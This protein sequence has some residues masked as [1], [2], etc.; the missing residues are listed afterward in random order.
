MR[1][2]PVGDRALLVEVSTARR[3]R[4]C[5]PSCCAAA[6]TGAALRARDRP[7]RPYGPPGRARR[8]E[9][10][11]RKL[12]A[13]PRRHAVTPSPCARSRTG[14]ASCAARNAATGRLPA[15]AA[16]HARGPP[17][18]GRAPGGPA[19]SR[20]ASAKASPLS[21]AAAPAAPITSGSADDALATTGVPQASASSAAS[22]NVSAGPGARHDVGRGLER[23]EPR[24]G[25]RHGRGRRPAAA[26]PGARG[27]S[28]ARSG[29]SPAT[30]SDAAHA[31]PRAARP[32]RRGPCP[33]ASRRDS[34]EHSSSSTSAPARVPGAQR[35]C[36]AGPAGSRP[37]STPSGARTTLRAPIRTN[38][39]SAHS[40]VHTI[41]E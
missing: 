9:H 1:A 6:P 11:A 40:V 15:E 33:A 5:T 41:R 14:G 13:P 25:R 38:S 31:A 2:L 17:R 12:G 16:R 3:P 21:A 4:P 26:P 36:C 20:T 7:G 23:A 32:A 8:A 28:A 22:P 19:A 24:R 30:T 39:R 10:F 37:R 35:R 29:P 27:S 34:R 18:G